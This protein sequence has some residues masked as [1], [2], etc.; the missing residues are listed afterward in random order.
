MQVVRRDDLT[1][2]PGLKISASLIY[3]S[4]A[5]EILPLLLKCL[6]I[7]FSGNMQGI[8]HISFT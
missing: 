4:G 7:H 5:G 2:P 8:T 3:F 6:G 1:V